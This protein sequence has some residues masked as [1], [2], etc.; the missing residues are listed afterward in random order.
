MTRFQEYDLRQGSF[1][2]GWYEWMPEFLKLKPKGDYPCG[3]CDLIALC[4]QCPGWAWLEH[5]NPESP[6]DYLCQI[7]HLRAQAFNTTKA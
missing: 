1:A 4:G 5:A 3:K 6:V 2:E 7:A